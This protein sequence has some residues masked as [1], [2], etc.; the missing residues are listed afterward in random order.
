MAKTKIEN[1]NNNLIIKKLFQDKQNINRQ[2][3]FQ[4]NMHA[5]MGY[6]LPASMQGMQSFLSQDLM[7]DSDEYNYTNIGTMGQREA[8][9]KLL[10][11]SQKLQG[12]Y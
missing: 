6:N 11:H 9:R 4:Q 10:K 5:M 12:K 1:M 8:N 3:L 2:A 7:R